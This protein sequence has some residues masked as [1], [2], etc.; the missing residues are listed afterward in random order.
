MLRLSIRTVP[1]GVLFAA[2]MLWGPIVA[3]QDIDVAAAQA[4][5][6]QARSTADQAKQI[7]DAEQ[8]RANQ[9]ASALSQAQSR[10]SDA[11][12]RLSQAYSV[13]TQIDNQIAA[14]QTQIQSL[15]FQRQD[16]LRQRSDASSALSALQ[17]RQRDFRNRVDNLQRDIQRLNDQI[18]RL[19]NGPRRGEYE[20]CYVDTG[21]EEHRGGHC[22]TNQNRD[23]AD[24]AAKAACLSA[25]PTCDFNS[26]EQPEPPELPGLRNQRDLAQSNLN[27]AQNDLQQTTNDI[28]SKIRD[29]DNI[30]ANISRAEQNIVGY[31]SDI[32]VQNSRK[33]SQQNVVDRGEQE[34]WSCQGDTSNAQAAVNGEIPAL[35][36]ARVSW[37]N[38]E[39]QAQSAYNY[40][41][42]VLANYN[43]ARDSV[44]AAADAAATQHGD[45]E[46]ND[47]APAT[48]QTDG[49]ASASRVGDQQGTSEGQARDQARG[50][51]DGRQNAASSALSTPYQSGISAGQA[52][53]VAK[54]Q[55][56]D[57]PR[58]YNDAL[59][60]LLAA[61]PAQA[62]TVDITTQT[63]SDPGGNG[64]DLSP[65]NQ[66]IGNVQAPAFQAP[67]APAYSI[68]SAPNPT[69]SVPTVDYRYR[70]APCT[71]LI[72][73]E[74][75]PL[76][77]AR[78]D[79]TYGSRFAT[80][81]TTVYR[82]SF[83][84]TFS[85]NVQASYDAALAR[86][87]S[88][89]FQAGQQR[90]AKEQ[91]ILDGFAA[92][93]S[94]A[95]T[96]QYAAGQHAVQT[97]L[98]TGHM[99]VVRDVKL[100]EPSGDG[101]YTPGETA[102]LQIVIDNYGGQATPLGKVRVRLTNKINAET[103][104]FDL[105]D[106]PALAPGTRTTLEGVVAVKIATAAPADKVELVG[107]IEVKDPGAATYQELEPLD[108]Q[109]ILHFPLEAQTLTLARKPQVDEEVP[110]K[111]TFKNLTGATIPATQV[112]FAAS[113]NVAQ[114]TTSP[115]AVPELAAGASIDVDA[116]VKP[117][118][119]VSDNTWVNFVATAANV[120]GLTQT[121][122]KFPQII[123]VDR[124]AS[125]LLFD[126]TGHAVP[127]STFDVTAG[128]TLS[129]QVK[130]NFTSTTAQPGPFVIRYANA[131]D[132]AISPA[133]G[134]TISTNLGG[135]SPGTSMGNLT[136]SFS[137]P[138][139]M[140]GQQGWV[141]I[142]LNEGTRYIHALQVYMNIR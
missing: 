44:L 93:L 40:L 17:D 134:S 35:N 71:G 113:P 13:M 45:H 11:R 104:S 32:N 19:E 126:R 114:V 26:C 133:S 16:Y 5:Y 64:R 41:Q 94:A 31:Q 56:E 101:L 117:G 59:G 62:A 10:E 102:T 49:V 74:F 29:I 107:E 95:R 120:G 28:N 136:F 128:T 88:T 112:A 2:A 21:F 116:K 79:A 76:C 67:T 15:Q 92:R 132:P 39:A 124:H 87:Y 141:M 63:S 23:A 138:A 122:Q 58:G 36:S 89:D 25:H 33:S 105:R 80:T 130:F 84:S 100:I 118:V 77:R 68:P 60:Q 78:Y 139:S 8:S 46:A 137:V 83:R 37:Q 123:T 98:A 14:D 127:N 119:W 125:L 135:W 22:S 50:Y 4:R 69:V 97:Y 129:F 65:T 27:Q 20:C 121:Q 47:R 111:I 72:R 99:I 75:E 43:A 96:E 30:D 52:D 115:V 18:N 53:A 9:L 6:A 142:Q 1:A 90:G 73:P 70:N 48:A 140:R 109:G 66:P 110:A 82:A 85:A 55:A 61:A 3:A 86:T 42:Q 12:N 54:A 81:Y 34:V 7:F 24:A 51:Q 106:L 57:A 103:V 108:V 131:S 38:L 91:G